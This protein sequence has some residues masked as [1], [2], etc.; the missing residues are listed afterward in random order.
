M[1]KI[2]LTVTKSRQE[3]EPEV[4]GKP[5][6][7]F[8]LAERTKTDPLAFGKLFDIYHDRIF[9]YLVRRTAN[10]HLAQELTS[11]TF[12]NALKRLG[13]LKG[14]EGALSG[15]LYRIA[16]NEVNRYYRKYKH[17]HTVSI[18]G[19]VDKIK[20]ASIQT[21]GRLIEAETRL[22]E[23][24]LFRKMH[25]EIA[26]LKTKYQDVIVLKYFENKKI[27][28]ISRITGKSEGT[29]KSLLHRAHKQLRSKLQL[30]YFNE[31][32]NHE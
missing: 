11:N 22:A 3:K 17:Y 18:D 14:K 26:N 25:G 31:G 10:I 13:Q 21:D 27:S 1:N 9:K 16:T 32:A 30:T 5:E 23:N 12:F 15:W 4:S 28:E 19:Y 6:A 20:D 2:S 24:K 29:V 8:V 7:E